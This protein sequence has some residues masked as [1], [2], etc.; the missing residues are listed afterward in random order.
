MPVLACDV[1]SRLEDM[2]DENDHVTGIRTGGD[3]LH[4]GETMN[5]ERDQLERYFEQIPK[6]IQQHVQPLRSVTYPSTERETSPNT[7]FELSTLAMPVLACDVQSRL[8]DMHDEN[9]HVTSIRIGGDDLH[10]GETMDQQLERC[11][12]TSPK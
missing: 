5:P 11:L 3:D 6:M 1:Q 2:H 4:G 10:G 9:D 7:Q 8:E 12:N